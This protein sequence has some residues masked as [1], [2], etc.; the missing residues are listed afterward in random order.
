MIRTSVTNCWAAFGDDGDIVLPVAA[1]EAK[2]KLN[3]IPTMK[4]TP[5][6]GRNLRGGGQSRLSDIERGMK[7][8]LFLSL[9]GSTGNG[10]KLTGSR[11]IMSGWVQSEGVSDTAAVSGRWVSGE[12][13]V[14]HR[15]GKLAGSPAVSFTFGASHAG[16]SLSLSNLRAWSP[17]PLRFAN[18]TNSALFPLNRMLEQ[19]FSRKN[20][21]VGGVF[22]STF[23]RAMIIALVSGSEIAGGNRA[24]GEKGPEGV[25][26]LEDISELVKDYNP[27]NLTEFLPW[28]SDGYKVS[29]AML[30][31]YEA[32]WKNQNLWQAI[33]A[34]ANFMFLSIVPYN[35]GFYIANPFGWLTTPN[36]TLTSGE[37][38]SLRQSTAMN[39]MEPVNGVVVTI[40]PI[41]NKDTQGK[42]A[43]AYPVEWNY[44]YPPLITSG[45]KPIYKSKGEATGATI[46]QGMYYHRRSLPSWLYPAASRPFGWLNHD[47]KRKSQVRRD[48]PDVDLVEW[49]D[50]VGTRAAR[51]VYAQL[52]SEQAAASFIVPYREDIMPGTILKIE[53]DNSASADT[54]IVGDTL[55]GMVSNIKIYCSTLE[56]SPV[57]QM[58]VQVTHLRGAGDNQEPPNGVALAETP[59][60]Q[61]AWVGMDLFGELLA[62]VPQGA[63]ASNYAT[64]TFNAA[65]GGSN[66]NSSS[67]AGTSTATTPGSQPQQI[68]GGS[69]FAL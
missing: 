43:G 64:K 48:K 3:E 65:S 41:I 19:L 45:G 38:T 50:Q 15:A 35:E 23:L 11:K 44:F 14:I 30:T 12:I 2:Y 1:F 60:Y 58:E 4:I 9:E 42:D 13:G 31:R 56:E 68:G 5:A 21:D 37:Y 69:N 67:S 6:L 46:K 54:S 40:P 26:S 18:N 27:A 33:L 22:P 62:D 34:A 7:V 61:N 8:E 59:L 51:W 39:V 66:P 57:L 36:L 17:S 53:T 32:G 10:T 28:L 63:E 25:F 52:L 49:A 55:Y 29:E 47:P 24:A 20:V 16:T